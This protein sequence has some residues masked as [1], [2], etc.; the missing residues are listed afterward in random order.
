MVVHHVENHSYASLVQCLHHLLELLDS[1]GREI[2][3]GGIA[4]LGHIVV[5]RVVAP[6]VLRRV[7]ACL[8]NRG[9]VERRQDVYGVHAERLQI[10]CRLGFRER[11]KFALVLQARRRVDGEIAVVELIDDEVA[12]RLQWRTLVLQPTVGV[13]A[14][15]V[16]YGGTVSVHPH[17]LGKETGAFAVA[18]VEG[19]ELA[20]YVAFHLSAPQS[21]FR[22]L[23]PDGFYGFAVCAVVVEAQGGFI[24]RVQCEDSLVFGIEHLVED[25]LCRNS[26]GEGGCKQCG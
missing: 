9:I 15:H 20:A 18:G 13:G 7:E 2:G 23:H 26:L 1:C 6:V 17:S 5:L 25:A 16:Y 12:G 19:V 3:V 11:K 8:V 10:F 4:A 22:L 14:A 21:V 24:G